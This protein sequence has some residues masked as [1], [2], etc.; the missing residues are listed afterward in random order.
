MGKEVSSFLQNLV[1][2]LDAGNPLYR[3][4]HELAT[5]DDV[6][7]ELRPTIEQLAGDIAGGSSF[8]QALAKHPA[9]FDPGYVALV[10][11]FEDEM[12]KAG[13]PVDNAPAQ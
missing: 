1:T 2:K 3:S 6:A 7:A 10:R 5:S 4:L 11:V 12:A 13:G 8:A 9:V